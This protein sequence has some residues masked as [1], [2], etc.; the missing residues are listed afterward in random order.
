[1]TDHT[2]YLSPFTWRCGSDDMR[3]IFSEIHRRKLWRRI[4]VA[5]SPRPCKIWGSIGK[6][7]AGRGP[8]S[9]A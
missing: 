8:T 9:T 5:L 6:K 2:T 4:W 3:Q 7:S 1:M